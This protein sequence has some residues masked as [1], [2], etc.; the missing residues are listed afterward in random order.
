MRLFVKGQLADDKDNNN[1]QDPFIM[2]QRMPEIPISFPRE[3]PGNLGPRPQSVGHYHLCQWYSG[4]YICCLSSFVD[5]L[6]IPVPYVLYS[7]LMCF[8]NRTDL[9]V[10]IYV[11]W[12]VKLCNFPHPHPFPAAGDV[13]KGGGRCGR[14]S[15]FLP[16][17]SV[18]C[19]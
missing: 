9:Q 13:A 10:G 3:K 7:N 19:I 17:C 8:S 1:H 18:L 16:L 11:P 6:Y 4:N 5:R 2:Q 12:Y 14:G 15:F